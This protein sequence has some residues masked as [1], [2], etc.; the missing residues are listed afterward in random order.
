M[1]DDVYKALAQASSGFV[2]SPAGCGKTEAIVRTVGS[3]CDGRQLILTHTHAG[4]DALS[5]DF[6]IILFRPLCTILTRLLAGL[7]T[8]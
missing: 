2:E 1:S 5:Q 4:V 7:G 6:D 8:G 3:Y